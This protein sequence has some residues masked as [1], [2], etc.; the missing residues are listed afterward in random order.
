M[1]KLMFIFVYWTKFS[2]NNRP[3]SKALDRQTWK[4]VTVDRQSYH[5]IEAL[6]KIQGGRIHFFLFALRV[7]SLEFPRPGKP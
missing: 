5:P 3:S 7:V 4:K 2:L 1:Q 6:L